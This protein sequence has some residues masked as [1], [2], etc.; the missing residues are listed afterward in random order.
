MTNRADHTDAGGPLA[1]VRVLDMTQFLAGPFC[2]QILADLGATVTKVEA[3]TGDITRTIPP[4][5]V[6]GDSA[7]FLSANRN[8]RS[9][10]VDLKS[11]GGLEL[12]QRLAASSD[13]VVE[14]FRPG[15]LARLGFSY[16]G[17][18]ARH[19]GLIWC[20]ISGFGQDGPT[21]G[22]PAYDMVVQAMS[23]GMSLTGE[24]EGASVRAGVP[25]GNLS[26]ALFATVGILAALEE[27]H[28]SGLGQ[29]VDVSLLDSHVSMLSYQAVYHLVA[30]V[31][32][33]R[34]GRGHDSIPTYRAFTAGD[35]IDV[36][37]TANTERM[38]HGLCDLLDRP[39]LADDPRFLTN[40]DRYRNRSELWPLLEE[41]FRARP[42]SEHVQRLHAA[43][44][45]AAVVVTVDRALTHP[46]VRH[47][48]M[49]IDVTSASGETARLLGNPIK[50]SRTNRNGHDF[51]PKLGADTEAVLAELGLTDDRAG[52][53]AA[54]DGTA[55]AAAGPEAWSSW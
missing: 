47:R 27:R 35:G 53:V 14:N 29:I 23:G 9:I 31:V 22:L 18:E 32:P 42:A 6:D 33:G 48:G 45:P 12:A 15:V 3:P 25:I 11:P 49:V 2:T 36:V 40:Q 41:A 7:Y 4:H 8:K 26:G 54:P 34:Q 21:A 43:A 55:R 46:Q 1:H 5:F 13:V 44:I 38:W 37:V 16:A 52:D 51:P 24:P 17:L 20:S 19:P 50:F 10:V 28:R 39:A 30:G